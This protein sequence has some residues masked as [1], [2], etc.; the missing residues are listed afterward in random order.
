MEEHIFFRA[1][2]F[3]LKKVT[4]ILQAIA[5]KM[6]VYSDMPTNCTINYAGTK[7]ATIRTSGN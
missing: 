3:T 2:V 4:T 6:P 1:K 5:N 7:S